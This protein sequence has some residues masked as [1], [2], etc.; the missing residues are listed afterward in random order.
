MDAY[1][2]ATPYQGDFHV[3][4]IR[5]KN[6][7]YL[8]HWHE[9]AELALV[10][11]GRIRLG[12]N[13]T[14]TTLEAGD[15]A[16]FDSNVIHYYDGSAE[17][18][19]IVVLVFDPVLLGE[20]GLWPGGISAGY[21]ER[22]FESSFFS[23]KELEARSSGLGKRI[24]TLLLA[25]RRELNRADASSTLMTRGYLMELAGELFRHLPM[26]AGRIGERTR[27]SEHIQSVLRY[28][29][30]SYTQPLDLDSLAI[31][32]GLSPAYL[33]R[34]FKRYAGIGY[35][36]YLNRIRVARAEELLLQEGSRV[37]DVLL[38]CGFESVRTF[39]RVFKEVAG[40]T[41]TAVRRRTTRVST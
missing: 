6:N 32:S 26:K 11:S 21:G 41:P 8:A 24:E 4:A 29:E 27:E 30:R 40:R 15:L 34:L 18:S 14:A 22:Y 36:T 7:T 5:A 1:R 23:S 20:R 10:L 3:K 19:D 39:N 16:I 9:D 31:R 12:A 33:S 38:A 17:P 13:D 25:I 2:E 28:L 35:R 37:T